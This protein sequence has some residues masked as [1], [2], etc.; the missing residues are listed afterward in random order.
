MA[1]GRFT[2]DGW[3]RVLDQVGEGTITAKVTVDQ[4]Y[5]QDQHE[6]P[7]YRHNDGSMKFVTGPLLKGSRRWLSAVARNILTT[8]PKEIFRRIAEEFADDVEAATPTDDGIL[9]KSAHPQ[10][11]ERGGVVYDRPP[12]MHRLSEAEIREATRDES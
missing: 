10:V 6:N 7:R 11:L 12:K 1:R 4:V 9:D 8:D 3:R 2:K 5:A